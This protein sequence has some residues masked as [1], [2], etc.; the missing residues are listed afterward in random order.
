[1]HRSSWL[2]PKDASILNC[3]GVV[4][5]GVHAAICARSVQHNPDQFFSYNTNL[6]PP[7]QVL[8]DTN[9]INGAI[10]TKQDVLQGL[11]TCLV[12]KCK[13]EY[14][15]EIAQPLF[16]R[17]YRQAVVFSNACFYYL[18]LLCAPKATYA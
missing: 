4:Q 17:A 3:L 16:R 11:I 7:Y 2:H 6:V 18:Y 13:L 1:M 15:C 14:G 8:V 12:A 9:F 10:Q 5:V